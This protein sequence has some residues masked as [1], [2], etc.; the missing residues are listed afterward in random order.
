MLNHQRE[1]T[2]PRLTAAPTATSVLLTL[3][4]VAAGHAAALRATA[5]A[6]PRVGA[7]ARAAAGRH[8]A[9]GARGRGVPAGAL[10]PDAGGAARGVRGER[11]ADAPMRGAAEC[12]GGGGPSSQT[13]P[14]FLYFRSKENGRQK[15]NEQRL[16]RERTES[17]SVPR[18]LLTLRGHCSAHNRRGGSSLKAARQPRLEGR[19]LRSVHTDS[20]PSGRRR[21]GGQARG[22]GLRAQVQRDHVHRLRSAHASPAEFHPG[23]SENKIGEMGPRFSRCSFSR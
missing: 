23:G 12:G 3:Q 20:I 15:E 18:V 7:R 13:N 5:T 14:F 11:A 9:G 16:E 22:Q 4:F 2:L 1:L 19:G 10:A 6:G 21:Q 17:R 8:G